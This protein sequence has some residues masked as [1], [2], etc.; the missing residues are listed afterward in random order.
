VNDTAW[1]DG[2]LQLVPVE[3]VDRLREIDVLIDKPVATQEEAHGA[4]QGGGSQHR[5]FTLDQRS[6]TMGTD[7]ETRNGVVG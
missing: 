6:G 1:P 7:L 4:G 3:V 2:S 5:P